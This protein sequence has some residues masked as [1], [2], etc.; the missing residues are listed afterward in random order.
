MEQTYSG[1]N[2]EEHEE[3]EEE[4]ADDLWHVEEAGEVDCC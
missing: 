1:S 2:Q 3:G 4:T